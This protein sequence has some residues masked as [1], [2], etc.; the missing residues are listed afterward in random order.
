MPTLPL[1]VAECLISMPLIATLKHSETRRCISKAKGNPCFLHGFTILEVMVALVIMG[2]SIGVFFSL[3]GNSARLRGKIN[4]HAKLL[5]LAGAKS[6]E[7]F[8]GLFEK[9]FTGSGGKRT[10][11]GRTKEGV[12]WKVC[13]VKSPEPEKGKVFPVT[14]RKTEATEL[15]LPQGI[16]L[17]TI[18]VEGITIDTIAIDDN[19][20]D[21]NEEKPITRK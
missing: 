20:S 7:A 3:I 11:A 16:K 2:I 12:P 15:F 1:K 18:Q 14:A 9:D 19:V 4:E 17:L 5:F 6:E 10:A 8:L 21:E 13:E